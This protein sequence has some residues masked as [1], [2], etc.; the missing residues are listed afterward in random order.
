[1]KKYILELL[2][3]YIVNARLLYSI[4]TITGGCDLFAGGEN[5]IIYI[6]GLDYSKITSLENEISNKI[7]DNFYNIF[8]ESIKK[9]LTNK[10]MA[11]LVYSQLE[12]EIK[13]DILKYPFLK[14]ELYK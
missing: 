10:E 4:E 2:E 11:H 9:K 1:M 7:C 6:M 5:S 3:L 14:N 12:S 8:N 13:K